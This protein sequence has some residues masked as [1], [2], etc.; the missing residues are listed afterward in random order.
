MFKNDISKST[1][2]KKLNDN[3]TDRAYLNLTPSKDP[4]KSPNPDLKT[5]EIKEE[6]QKDL[7][8]R[9]KLEWKHQNI[10]KEMQKIYKKFINQLPLRQSIAFISKEINDLKNHNSLIQTCL[11]GIKSREES[12]ISIKE[13]SDYLKETHYWYKIPEIGTECVEILHAHR[14]MT[15]TVAENIEKWM[16]LLAFESS[17]FVVD[18][19][20]NGY[21]YLTKIQ[22]DLEFLKTSEMSRIFKFSNENDPFLI[23]PSKVLEKHNIKE[24]SSPLT[25]N[26]YLNI[27]IPPSIFARISEIDAFLKTGKPTKTHSL[28]KFFVPI[29]IIS[30]VKKTNTINIEKT[31]HK[32]IV[33]EILLDFIEIAYMSLINNCVYSAITDYLAEIINYGQ[34]ELIFTLIVNISEAMISDYPHELEIIKHKEEKQKRQSLNENSKKQAVNKSNIRPTKIESAYKP[35]EY[36][37]SRSHV[38]EKNIKHNEEILEKHAYPIKSVGKDII[39]KYNI[40]QQEIIQRNNTEKK[41]T[42][43]N[44]KII[45][46]NKKLSPERIKNEG[47]YNIQDHGIEKKYLIKE[48]IDDHEQ[49]LN[50]ILEENSSKQENEIKIAIKN[51]LTHAPEE[52]KMK[53][54]IEKKDFAIKKNEGQTN[55]AKFSKKDSQSI[56]ISTDMSPI[57]AKESLVHPASNKFNNSK[58]LHQ[59]FNKQLRYIDSNLKEK[60]F[61]MLRESDSF[62][63]KPLLETA[64]ISL[65][66]DSKQEKISSKK[67]IPSAIKLPNLENITKSESP[68]K[69]KSK[70]NSEIMASL[71]DPD[72]HIKEEENQNEK[73]QKKEI[74]IKRNK[75]K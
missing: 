9:L 7:R 26:N 40:E 55:K 47:F 63:I 50:T 18:F 2:I 4:S 30:P 53:L 11:S 22:N 35:D 23:F 48:I 3:L 62:V 57:T 28:N 13:M 67:F 49:K 44:S 19:I 68:F 36:R 17:G 29:S 37:R 1:R 39:H 32:Q 5:T 58:G 73:K 27:P 52:N 64:N 46:Q 6:V 59:E 60:K 42:Q 14:V 69:T 70:L 61:K 24:K 10:E 56:S 33:N 12:L 41:Y 65:I 8:E 71:N 72:L 54:S 20:Y 43:K 31:L 75:E 74:E 25:K 16:S 34:E 51:P 21:N 45:D 38:R 66:V 15:L